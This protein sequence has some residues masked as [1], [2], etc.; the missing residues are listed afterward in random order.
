MVYNA[1]LMDAFNLEEISGF[2]K[3]LEAAFGMTSR[4][5]ER[6]ASSEMTSKCGISCFV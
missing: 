1:I 2:N 4:V 6:Y 3:P 5:N